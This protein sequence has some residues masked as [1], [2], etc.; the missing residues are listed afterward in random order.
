[1]NEL[2]N[3]NINNIVENK[4]NIKFR[5]MLVFL[6][7]GIILIELSICIIIN[8]NIKSK[9]KNKKV[10]G[11]KFGD[12]II[13]TKANY[14]YEL[15]DEKYDSFEFEK[16]IKSA[17]SKY[18][19]DDLQVIYVNSIKKGKSILKHKETV[20]RKFKVGNKKHI[21][22]KNGKVITKQKYRQVYYEDDCEEEKDCKIIEYHYVYTITKDN[23]YYLLDYSYSVDGQDYGM[24]VSSKKIEK[25]VDNFIK[26]INFNSKF[27]SLDKYREEAEKEIKAEKVYYIGKKDNLYNYRYKNLSFSISDD[28]PVY[29]YTEKRKEQIYSIDVFY[30]DYGLSVDEQEKILEENNYQ[31]W[32]KE[33]IGKYYDGNRDF[34]YIY[35][36]D[37]KN[38]TY[39]IDLEIDIDNYE[40]FEQ[41]GKN[42][43]E[44]T[45]FK[46][47]KNICYSSK[48][49]CEQ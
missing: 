15:Y 19:S 33:Y 4:S 27:Y 37:M 25:E 40:H 11:V 23:N 38:W 2:N 34:H 42:F 39:K 7:L 8:N 10:E 5:K 41:L 26:T 13:P 17:N 18:F 29:A 24:I 46:I 48:C 14:E 45:T 3:T 47:C 44:N 16:L 21:R 49:T 22:L 36:S 32:Y 12:L 9:E 31:V 20:Y 28:I 6:F 43:K 35:V 30:K 1:M